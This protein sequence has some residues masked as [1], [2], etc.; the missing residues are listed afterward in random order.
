MDAKINDRKMSETYMI[1][2]AL[3]ISLINYVNPICLT[4]LSSYDIILC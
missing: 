3:H 1:D 2:H 4:M